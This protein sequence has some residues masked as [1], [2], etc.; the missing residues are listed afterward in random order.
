VEIIMSTYRLLDVVPKGRDEAGLE[1]GM[2]WLRHH[3]RYEPA[4]R[5]PA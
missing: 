3:D 2:E 5:R 1:Y 4:V